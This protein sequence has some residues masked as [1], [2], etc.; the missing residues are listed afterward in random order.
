MNVLTLYATDSRRQ[1]NACIDIDLT[2]GKDLGRRGSVNITSIG[3]VSM[4]LISAGLFG[5]LGVRNHA[6]LLHESERVH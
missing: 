4:C 2:E 1:G 3:F 5:T 6:E